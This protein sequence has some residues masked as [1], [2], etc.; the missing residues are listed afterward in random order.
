MGGGLA[1]WRTSRKDLR[2]K[3]ATGGGGAA[4]WLRGA[5]KLQNNI[6]GDVLEVPPPNRLGESVV[7]FNGSIVEHVFYS[8][9]G[10]G[11]VPLGDG[12][13][14]IGKG[15]ADYLVE[16]LRLGTYGRG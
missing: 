5:M 9:E 10:P 13:Q 8:D 4:R 6:T 1:G 3:D 11:S 14:F 12:K 16:Q 2:S 15:F 7:L